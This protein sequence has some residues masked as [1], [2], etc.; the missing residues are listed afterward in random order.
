MGSQSPP[1]ASRSASP[2]R[3]TALIASA[4]ASVVNVPGSPGY[5]TAAASVPIGKY[6]R[7]GKV[8]TLAPAG[9]VMRPAPNGQA[10]ASAR[11]SV[12]LPAPDGPGA[13][14]CSPAAMGA[15]SAGAAGL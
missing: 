4:S 7:C 9:T 8:M 6:G 12:G 5:V 11:D 2:G 15:A 10:P 3:P 14:T 13:S 1:S